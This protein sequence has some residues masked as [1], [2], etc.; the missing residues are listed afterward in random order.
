MP[1]TLSV[2]TYDKSGARTA[3]VG[4]EI[5]ASVSF[6]KQNGA[7]QTAKYGYLAYKNNGT[8]TNEKFYIYLKAQLIYK[9]GTLKS[10]WIYVRIH[11]TTDTIKDEK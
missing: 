3:F 10:D 2:G 1:K 9:W 7:A 6:K 4:A 5:P 8:G 11:P